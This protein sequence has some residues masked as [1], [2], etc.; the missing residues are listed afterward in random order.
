MALLCHN[1]SQRVITPSFIFS[2][3]T[4]LLQTSVTG[5]SQPLLSPFEQEP[6]FSWRQA[7]DS[8]SPRVLSRGRMLWGLASP[9][10]RKVWEGLLGTSRALQL[11]AMGGG[12]GSRWLLPYR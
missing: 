5:L 8:G 2:G 12:D 1:K 10:L 9:G 11:L 3:L 4:V 7:G 6:E